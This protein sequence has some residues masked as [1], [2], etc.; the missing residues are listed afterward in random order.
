MF[1]AL[2]DVSRGRT[3]RRELLKRRKINLYCLLS[4]KSCPFRIVYFEFEES[5]W[6]YF[7]KGQE[8]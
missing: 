2:Q 1:F 3:P 8:M 6:L 7:L 4:I 5:F